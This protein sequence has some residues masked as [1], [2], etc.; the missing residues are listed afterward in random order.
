MFE[1]F[2]LKFDHYISCMSSTYGFW[3]K[4]TL[5]RK[6][7]IQFNYFAKL[8]FKM[9]ILFSYMSHIIKI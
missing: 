7:K 3:A 4:I 2:E 1:Y 5:L 9:I 8:I 6:K